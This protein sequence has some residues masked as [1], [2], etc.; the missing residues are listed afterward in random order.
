[1]AA[2]ASSGAVG[3]E[4]LV[5]EAQIR[6]SESPQ[7]AFRDSAGADADLRELVFGKVQ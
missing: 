5:I 6:A 1:M 7:L 4:L 3:Y 2:R